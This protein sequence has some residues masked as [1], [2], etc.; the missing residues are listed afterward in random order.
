MRIALV[1]DA[2]SNPDFFP[3]LA[4]ELSGQVLGIETTEKVA[5][6]PAD[7]PLEA[8]RLA[9]N[10]GAI[11]VFSEVEQA[12]LPVIIGRLL[13]IELETGVKIIKAVRTKRESEGEKEETAAEFAQLIIESLFEEKALV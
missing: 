11:F 7:I 3:G 4:N 8:K 6:F 12:L 2:K 9:A 5:A 10:C 13:D 1:S